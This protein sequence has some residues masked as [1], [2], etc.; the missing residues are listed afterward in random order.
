M[1]TQEASASGYC[2]TMAPASVTR[3]SAVTEGP[4]VWI[5]TPVGGFSLG[6]TGS[7][8]GGVHE[9]VARITLTRR[10]ADHKLVEIYSVRGD[11]QDGG[12]GPSS[13]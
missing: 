13:R 2:Q 3:L 8:R 1:A 11:L 10:L 9:T 4:C 7:K 5:L 6:N 12:L